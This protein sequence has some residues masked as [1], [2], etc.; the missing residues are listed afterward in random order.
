[1][2]AIDLL[3]VVAVAGAAW[4][5][6]RTGLAVQVGM[7]VGLVLGLLLGATVAP[8]VAGWADGRTAKA[9]R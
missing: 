4:A 7:F 5:G 9:L 8:T 2:T 3:I 6:V 1:M